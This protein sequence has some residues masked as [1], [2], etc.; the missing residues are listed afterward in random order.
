MF[1][2]SLVWYASIR[3]MTSF[4][5]RCVL[6]CREW[7]GWH[8]PEL[9]RIIQDPLAYA[10]VSG[11]AWF[12]ADIVLGGKTCAFTSSYASFFVLTESPY[13]SCSFCSV[14][15]VCLSGDKIGWNETEY[16]W[17]RPFQCSSWRVR[18]ESERRSRNQHGNWHFGI[19]F[20]PDSLPLWPGMKLCFF[21][22]ELWTDAV[23][24]IFSFLIPCFFTLGLFIRI[25]LWFLN[26]FL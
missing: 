19:W 12:L 25:L 6:R 5:N 11:V 7:Y 18:S 16:A 2:N 23:F 20:V 17:N 3:A 9:G 26:V 15:T 1:P 13:I 22:R 10:K 24:R 21:G 8:F 14:R 4:P